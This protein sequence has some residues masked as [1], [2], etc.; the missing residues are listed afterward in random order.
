MLGVRRLDFRAALKLTNFELI[1]IA[2]VKG[3]RLT[4]ES[5]DEKDS[6]HSW[7]NGRIPSELTQIKCRFLCI[8]NLM[9][10]SVQKKS[11]DLH[12]I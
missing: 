10:K 6:G 12:K 1:Y 8:C 7:P 11:S 5:S 3:T 2:S 9:Y 4:D